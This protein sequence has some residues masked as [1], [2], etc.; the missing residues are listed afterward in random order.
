MAQKTQKAAEK[1]EINS[2]PKIFSLSDLPSWV[3][4]RKTHR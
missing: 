3:R 4:R 1:P 2:N